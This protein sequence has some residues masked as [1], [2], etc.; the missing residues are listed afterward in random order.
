MGPGGVGYGGRMDD[1]TEAAVES[2]PA[3]LRDHL[4]LSAL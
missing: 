3:F 2:V 1:T 4:D